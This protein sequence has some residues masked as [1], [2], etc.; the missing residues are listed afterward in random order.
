VSDLLSSR[1]RHPQEGEKKKRDSRQITTHKS[2]VEV[3][4]TGNHIPR[5][6][7]GVQT[8]ASNVTS[9]KLDLRRKR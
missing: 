7:S 8:W 6:Y 4:A 9:G 5:F 2:T 1:R 3:G